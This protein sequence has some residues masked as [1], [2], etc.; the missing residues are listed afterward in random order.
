[1]ADDELRDNPEGPR[2][3]TYTPPPEDA[4]FT[5]SF[6]IIDDVQE[7]PAPI[8]PAP[9]EPVSPAP[10]PSAAIAPPVRASLSDAEILQKFS[11]EGA[12]TTAEM[13]T[14]LEAQVTLREEE[15]EAFE[16]WANLT[17]ATRG[18]DAPAIIARERAIFD[19][20]T[21]PAVIEVEV[22][23]DDSDS[24]EMG[25]D[26]PAPVAAA[27][28]LVDPASELTDPQPEIDGDEPAVTDEPAE[29]ESVV[30]DDAPTD[31]DEPE[32]SREAEREAEGDD[33]EQ[34]GES[35]DQW[36][37]AQSD[38]S[39]VAEPEAPRP[40]VVRAPLVD[41]IGLEPTPEN[42]KTLTRVGMFWLWWATLTPVVGIVA[43]AF[44][45]SRGLGVVET[46]VAL[47]ASALISGLV[48]AAAAFAGARTSLSTAH[49]SQV[50]FGRLGA[51]AP[52][53][54]LV[55][56]RVALLA[57]LIL[58]AESLVTRVV[59][60]AQWWPLELWILRAVVAGVVGALVVTLGILGGRILRI[61]LYAS[62][63]LSAL[64]LTG[65]I[66][67]TAP[68]IQVSDIEPWSSSGLTV[69]ALG[70][71][72]LVGFLILFGH[73]GGDLA[74]YSSGAIGG[75]GARSVSVLSGLVA[76]VPTLL[77]VTYVAWVASAT[78]RLAI[79]LVT[80]PAGSLAGLLPMWFPAPVLLG[81]VVPLVVLAAL[82]LFSGGLAVLSAGVAVP[83]MVGTAVVAALAFAGAGVALWFDHR[84]S[85]YFPDVVYLVGVVLA[86]WAG[87]YAT[88]IALGH[89]H[90]GDVSAGRVPRVRIAPLAGLVVAVAL[91]WGLVVSSVGWLSWLG[92]VFPLLDMAGLIDL[93]SAQPGILVALIFSAIVAAVAALAR[94][95]ATAEVVDG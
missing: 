39:P 60:L 25:D 35:D 29:V 36:P 72:A 40:A 55:I 61:A 77:F 42:H 50:T 9:I 53:A 51:I 74:R 20:L 64:A 90:L 14:E 73:T 86:A 5:G 21:P 47:G 41:R 59:V 8:K 78:P 79:T 54:L 2:R 12:G 87:A 83:R 85:Q 45:V 26:V 32:E 62:A 30:V 95:S 57:V 38:S 23:P 34:P 24:D 7:D 65:F 52:S 16:M 69:V 84:I 75:S 68:T 33:A 17:R 67:L 63:A 28:D 71:L 93:R 18:S 88:D 37:L 6:P 66:V 80:D 4:V 11:Q 91:G 70:S 43:G 13:I 56:I 94:R 76:V 46:V 1:M 81:L 82:S 44:L 89:K 15:E 31:D 3:R 48:I 49:T 58:A 10:A 19:G 22:S 92:Y 27:E